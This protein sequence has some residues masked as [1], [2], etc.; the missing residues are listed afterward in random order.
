MIA[1]ACG[2]SDLGTPQRVAD[3]LRRLQEKRLE[4]N[5]HEPA[6]ASVGTVRAFINLA[7]QHARQQSALCSPAA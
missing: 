6:D 2:W 1:P 5:T 4:S 7:A 3:T